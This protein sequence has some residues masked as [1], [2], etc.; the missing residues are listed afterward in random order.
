MSV[1]NQLLLQFK[2][3][4]LPDQ[5]LGGF[6]I[7]TGSAV[8]AF[9]VKWRGDITALIDG[10]HAARTTSG[11]KTLIDHF[12]GGLNNGFLLVFYFGTNIPAT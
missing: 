1:S 7:A 5:H 3:L 9:S 10:N 6:A 4:V 12:I 11:D 8:H 2:L